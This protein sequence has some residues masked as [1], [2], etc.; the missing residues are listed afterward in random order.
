MKRKLLFTLL[1]L[2]GSVASLE[3]Q[4]IVT[5]DFTGGMDGWVV[6]NLSTTSP[7]EWTWAEIGFEEFTTGADGSI[8][9]LGHNSQAQ[10]EGNSTITS[11]AFAMNGA[12]NATLKFEH[13]FSPYQGTFEGTLYAS[14]D[15]VTWEV[16]KLY[17]AEVAYAVERVD[18]SQYIENDQLY[19]RFGL[20]SE[21]SN[22][23]IVDDIEIYQP[24]AYDVDVTSLDLPAFESIQN[25][26]YTVSLNVLN[27]GSEAITSAE[28]TYVANGGTPVQETVSG[29]NIAS[30]A[31]GTISFTTDFAPAS[32]GFYDLEAEVLSLNGNDDSDASNNTASASMIVYDADNAAPRKPFFEIFTSSTCAPCTPGNIQYHSIVN[33]KPEDEYVSIKYQQDFPG[34]GDPYCTGEGLSRRSFYAINSIPR[35]EIDGGWDGNAASFTNTLYNQ[36]KAVPAIF[37]ISGAFTID[38]ANQ[39]VSYDLSVVPGLDLPAGFA[40]LYIAIV[41]KETTANKKTNGESKF[42]SVMKKMIPGSNGEATPAFTL[43][44]EV[45][46]SGTYVFQGNYRLPSN[47]QAANRIDNSSEHSVEE[48]EDLHVIAWIQSS[49]DLQVFQAGNLENETAVGVFE[50][51]KANVESLTVY[52][53][54]ADEAF[55]ASF[56]MATNANVDVKVINTAGQVVDA[57]S[58]TAKAGKVMVEFGASNL[59]SGVYQIQVEENGNVIA[60][61]KAVVAH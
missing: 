33:S 45:T 38:A 34:T 18:V 49:D 41:E 7:V 29:L 44:Q 4:T 28:I 15:G 51:E 32:P 60:T 57:R 6:E 10:H 58:I 1:G 31:T 36:A 22:Y 24:N 47:G 48:F 61:S 17:D 25:A 59:P 42:E 30:T 2:A 56:E 23:W 3:A 19:I 43:G 11:P 16:V 55:T 13:I 37:D 5:E 40:T 53:N 21:Y 50:L 20:V 8:Y 26:P 12:T 39:T 14:G 46:M 52:P 27:K 35:M 54:P 9:C